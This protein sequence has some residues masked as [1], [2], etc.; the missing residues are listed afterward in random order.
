MKI[1]RYFFYTS[2][3]LFL[4]GCTTT[5]K[6]IEVFTERNPQVD[7]GEYNTYSWI[8]WAEI[9]NDPQGRWEPGDFDAD[10]EIRWLIDSEL[11]KKGIVEFEKKPDLLVGYAAGINMEVMKA[12]KDPETKSLM[13]EKIPRGA[14]VIVLIDPIANTVVWK[15]V[16]TG[17]I[18][19]QTSVE[20]VRKRLGYAVNE[21]FKKYSR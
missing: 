8:G 9:I 16:A 5:T 17:D 19:N 20:Q 6:D 12:I 21:I 10:K 11:R 15:G 4:F 3:L 18:Q 7:F 13:V 14:L 1:F 2:L